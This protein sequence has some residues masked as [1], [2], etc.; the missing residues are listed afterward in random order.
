M[1]CSHPHCSDQDSWLN[2]LR[3]W[4]TSC[5][6][7]ATPEANSWMNNCI[8]ISF[9]CSP[10]IIYI[11]IGVMHW[12]TSCIVKSRS[13]SK[14]ILRVDSAIA[15]ASAT[16]LSEM[17]LVSKSTQ[18]NCK[19]YSHLLDG[20]SGNSLICILTFC[21]IDSS[22]ISILTYYFKHLFLNNCLP[23]FV[24]LTLL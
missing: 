12:V 1:P 21:H 24:W 10:Y 8:V 16:S 20:L 6:T 13:I 2:T 9:L 4:S 14:L 5:I 11:C 22:G 23:H 7:R 17:N 19:P 18:L 3:A 15:S